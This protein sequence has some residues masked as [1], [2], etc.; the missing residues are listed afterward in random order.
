MKDI[1]KKNKKII[2][3]LNHYTAMPTSRK[4]CNKNDYYYSEFQLNPIHTNKS[5][6]AQQSR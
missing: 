3:T 6:S 1:L 4:N 5:S 2:N